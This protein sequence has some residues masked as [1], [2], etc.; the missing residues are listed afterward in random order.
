MNN[1]N[2]ITIIGY[3]QTE[4]EYDD[5]I[6]TMTDHINEAGLPEDRVTEQQVRSVMSAYWLFTDDEGDDDE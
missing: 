2:R 3:G 6:K 4:Q 1:E 5:L